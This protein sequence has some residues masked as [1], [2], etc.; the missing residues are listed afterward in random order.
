MLDLLLYGKW[1]LQVIHFLEACCCL[2]TWCQIFPPLCFTGHWSVSIDTIPASRS[3]KRLR[4]LVSICMLRVKQPMRLCSLSFVFF[5]VCLI[6]ECS[7][8]FSFFRKGIKVK[9]RMW[10]SKRWIAYN[11]QTFGK[12]AKKVSS[13]T[14]FY[15]PHS[16]CL[17]IK[18]R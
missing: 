11:V 3:S 12:Y 10:K 9:R 16:L 8:W 6:G 14:N 7:N 5:D 1:R 13:T 17:V 18:N 15:F 2:A 4:E